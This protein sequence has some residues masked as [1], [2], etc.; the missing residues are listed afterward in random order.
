MNFTGLVLIE[1][2]MQII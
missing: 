2:L 1:K